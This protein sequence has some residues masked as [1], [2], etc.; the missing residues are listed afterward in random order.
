MNKKKS[1]GKLVK[2]LAVDLIGGRYIEYVNRRDTIDSSLVE[3]S[4]STSLMVIERRERFFIELKLY[5]I[6]NKS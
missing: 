3:R 1:I 6:V 4:M 5:L 2:L